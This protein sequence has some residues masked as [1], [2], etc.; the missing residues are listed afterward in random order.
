MTDDRVLGEVGEGFDL[1]K[2]ALDRGRL[3]VAAGAVGVVAAFI[4]AATAREPQ[5]PTWP[6]GSSASPEPQ[7]S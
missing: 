7:P 5:A 2:S 1:T 4:A 3:G 6:S